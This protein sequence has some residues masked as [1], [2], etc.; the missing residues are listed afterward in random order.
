MSIHNTY[1][2]SNETDPVFAI[3]ICAVHDSQHSGKCAL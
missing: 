3:T 1:S 2:F